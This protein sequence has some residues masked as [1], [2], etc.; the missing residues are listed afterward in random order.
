MPARIIQFSDLHLLETDDGE[1]RGVRTAACFDVV[2]NAVLSSYS[3]ADMFV[4]TGDIAAHAEEGAYR[5]VRAKC[6][7]FLPRSRMITGNHDDGG[8]LRR[9]FPDVVPGESGPVVFSESLGGW[10]LIGLDT[11]VEG[12]VQGRLSEAQLQWLSEELARFAEQPILLFMHHPPISVD[13]SWLDEIM[14]ENP[15]GLAAV[16]ASAPQ[17][18][19]VF[20]GHVHHEF[21]G[22][23][24][25]VPVYTVPSTAIQFAPGTAELVIDEEPPGFRVIELHGGKF[26]TQVVRVDEARP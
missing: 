20:C 15:E 6:E 1:L 19:A 12:A 3:D 26:A 7:P 18:R 14:L 22:R 13:S 24:G 5:Q 2:W 4:F 21:E 17:V 10:R 8:L 23:L 11:L 16:L 25:Q 9:C